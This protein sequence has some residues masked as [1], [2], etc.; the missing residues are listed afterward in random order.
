MITWQDLALLVWYLSKKD[1]TRPEKDRALHLAKKGV[2]W[3]DLGIIADIEGVAGLAYRNINDLGL[4]GLVPRPVLRRLKGIYSQT[5]KHTLAILCEAEAL[6]NGLRQIHIPV[7]AI[8]G[9][10]LIEIYGDPGLR[11]LGD[12]DLMVKPAHKEMLKRLL[13]ES[14]YRTSVFMYQALFNKDS[15]W[16]DIHT[17]ILNLD[18]IRTRRYLFPEDLTPM[19]NRAIPFSDQA[20]NLLRPDHYDNFIVLAAHALK[21]NY[22]RLIWLVDLHQLLLKCAKNRDGWERIVE[23][24]Q[25]WHQERVVLYALLILRGRNPGLKVPPWVKCKLGIQKLNILERHLLRLK[26]R[27]LTSSQLCTVLWLCNI[28]GTG[29]RLRF[30]RETIFPRGDIMG[31]IFPYSSGSTKRSVYAKRIRQTVVT[32]ARELRQALALSFRSGRSG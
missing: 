20:D 8:Q 11:Q 30:I 28:D 16:V 2:P 4:P 26:L 14:G 15:I 1:L 22:S 12:V 21:H 24:A 6:S 9:L 7:M 19:W 13:F 23:R 10:S 29:K 32:A 18:R 3:E 27:G 31:Q 5:K 25:F 17:H